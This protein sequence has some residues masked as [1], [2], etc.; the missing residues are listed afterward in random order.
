MFTH[1][2]GAD[3]DPGLA[4]HLDHLER[5]DLEGASC[6][7]RESVRTNE[8]AFSLVVTTLGLELDSTTGH[9]TGSQ[10]D[11]MH[12]VMMDLQMDTFYIFFS[13]TWRNSIKL[14]C[15][16]QTSPGRRIQAR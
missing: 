1:P 3:L 15:S 5:V 12:G 16:S 2:L 7:S 8:L 4:E 6:F 11:Q 14:T 13:P 10:P 9:H